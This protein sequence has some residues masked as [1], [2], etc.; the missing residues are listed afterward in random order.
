MSL[1]SKRTKGKAGLKAV[2]AAAKRPRLLLTGTK[3]A[4]PAAKAAYALGLIEPP[5]PKRTAPR[6]AA[7]AVLGAGA[8]Y[9]LDPEQGKQHRRRV[10]QLVT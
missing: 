3:F 2:K 6:I 5:K 8:V 4:V 7:G 1:I 10:A 9:L